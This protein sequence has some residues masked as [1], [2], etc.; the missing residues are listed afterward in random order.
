MPK[1]AN[2]VRDVITKPLEARYRLLRFTLTATDFGVPQIR[3][4]VFFVGFARK[5]DF[6]RFQEPIP[7]HTWSESG[8]LPHGVQRTM[9]LREALGLP[10]IGVDG[11]SP[12]IR[13][14][15]TGPRHTTSILNSMAGQ[16]AFERLEIWPNGVAPDHESARAFIAKNGQFR[17]SV[18]EVGNIQGFPESWRF[19]GAT[20]MQIGQI[21]NAV[22]PPMGYAVARS[23]A[24]ALG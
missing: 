7:T 4:R 13:S 22:A 19:Q 9:G 12:T 15:L 17:L 8:L 1:F 21:G 14:A 3:R 23:V 20:Y 6:S 24:E 10:D 18:P 11:P 2:Y 16:R 5:T